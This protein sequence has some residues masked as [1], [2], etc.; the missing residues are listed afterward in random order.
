MYNEQEEKRRLEIINTPRC[1]RDAMIQNNERV[2]YLAA[3][4]G[5]DLEDFITKFM[6]SEEADRLDQYL[7]RYRWD[8]GD[9]I[10]REFLSSCELYGIVL[11]KDATKW[12]LAYRG[13]I[14]EWIAYIYR[15]MHFM[16]VISGR[17]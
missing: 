4:E 5:Y 3:K 11:K 2:F 7:N 15:L 8:G 9:G 10:F 14:A 12:S 1:I 17:G 16:T 6:Y 13:V